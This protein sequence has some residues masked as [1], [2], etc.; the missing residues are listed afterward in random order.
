MFCQTSRGSTIA[1]PPKDGARHLVVQGT[2]TKLD[3]HSITLSRAIPEAGIT[4]PRLPFDYLVYALGSHS[5][6][7]INLWDTVHSG[8]RPANGTKQA[9]IEW[10]K[11]AQK[12]VK[13]AQNILIV[14]GGALGIRAH[15]LLC[16]VPHTHIAPE[17]A[18]DIADAYPD[19]GVTLLHSR[20]QLLPKFEPAMHDH[21]ELSSFCDSCSRKLIL[22]FQ[23]MSRMSEL[24]VCVIL[25]K[26][27]DMSSVSPTIL[28]GTKT[29]KLR[30]QCGCEFEADLV[31]SA[32]WA[33]L[34]VLLLTAG[35]VTVHWPEAEYRI[36]SEHATGSHHPRRRGSRQQGSSNRCVLGGERCH[37]RVGC[38]SFFPS[39]YL[40]Y[41]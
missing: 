16:S 36:A 6:E 25:G 29:H 24:G 10:L 37:E 31:V 28:D 27:L 1:V 17:Y 13:D 12:R 4:E 34:H 7:P 8:S 19:K 33:I 39:S 30:T 26:R 15:I 5:P 14:G 3:T 35:P 18:M 40:C 22:G 41:R 2:V 20:E 21:S 23:V 11:N 9:G 38:S 32:H